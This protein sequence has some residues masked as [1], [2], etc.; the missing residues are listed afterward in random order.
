MYKRQASR[1][2]RAVRRTKS[3]H[4][5]FSRGDFSTPSDEHR[6]YRRDE[7]FSGAYSVGITSRGSKQTEKRAISRNGDMESSNT[8][9]ARYVEVSSKML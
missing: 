6:E 5:S 8:M 2:L 3:G 9:A 1:D 4:S 7:I